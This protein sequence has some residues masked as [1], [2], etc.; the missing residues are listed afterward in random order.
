MPDSVEG[1]SDDWNVNDPDAEKVFYDLS[2]WTIDQQ[3]D[4]AA[5]LADQAIPHAWQG[6]ELVVP[7]AAEA[8]ADAIV[9]AIEQ[10]HGITYDDVEVAPGFDGGLPTT[11][12]DLDEWP[13]GDRAS[14]EQALQSQ[15]I[16]FH[17]DGNVLLVNTMHEDTVDHLLDLVENGELATAAVDLERDAAT[18]DPDDQLPFETLTTFFLAGERLRRNPLDADGLEELMAANEVADPDRPPYGV[19]RRLWVRMC[20]LADGL[21]AALCDDEVPNEEAAAEHAEALHEL[22]RPYV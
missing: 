7:P 11:E 5:E 3:A 21:V 2:S 15:R 22:L 10:R 9:E 13:E 12:Y 6:T 19:E 1:V 20:A 4:L 18:D 16:P 14:I 17:W 8:E